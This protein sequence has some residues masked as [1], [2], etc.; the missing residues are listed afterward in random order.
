MNETTETHEPI[1]MNARLDMIKA[2]HA[3]V[4]REGFVYVTPEVIPVSQDEILDEAN[5]MQTRPDSLAAEQDSHTWQNE[6][7]QSLVFGD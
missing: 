5:Q 7:M 3:K 1:D 2:A 4:K 6:F